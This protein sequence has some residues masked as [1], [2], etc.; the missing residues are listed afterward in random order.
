MTHSFRI[1]APSRLHFGLARFAQSE[2]R[3]FGGL[4]MMIKEP[5][6]VVEV[7][8]ADRWIATG[9]F[10]ERA[11][12]F[13]RMALDAADTQ[14][15]SAIQVKVVAAP[16]AHTGMG[17]GTQLALAVA[18]GV[19]SLS[20]QK[21]VSAARLANSVRRG[22]RSAVGTHGFQLGG[23]LWERGRLPQQTLGE[24]GAR[25]AVPHEWRVV[26]ATY[27]QDEGLS[28]AEEVGAFDELPPIPPEV[29]Q[30]LTL[31]A[32][33]SILPA[34]EASDF[35]AFAEAVYEYGYLAGTCFA[36]V[37]GGP[38]ASPRIAAA[39]EQIRALGVAG[40]GQSSWGPTIFA[41]APDEELALALMRKLE[42]LE[43]FAGAHL[44]SVAADNRGAQI[45]L[46]PLRTA[47]SYSK[48]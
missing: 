46:L 41:F 44:T 39:V 10:A 20:G 21:D 12:Q 48:P 15:V 6:V 31:L 16:A 33:R 30:R 23:L 43:E 22:V 11:L 14:A 3:S 19:F 37:Q 27:R 42:P 45:E 13:A 18:S 26:L 40:V 28:G 8:A 35:H 17:S 9:P 32:E 4:G 7:S 47:A 34:T 25:V 36:A 29:T 5:R 24:L 1:S 38:F 2:G